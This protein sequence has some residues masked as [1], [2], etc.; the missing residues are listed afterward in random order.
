MKSCEVYLQPHV[1]WLFGVQETNYQIPSEK[2]SAI[3]QVFAPHRT[4]SGFEK[5]SRFLS[6]LAAFDFRTPSTTHSD[7]DEIGHWAGWVCIMF[8]FSFFELQLSNPC[9]SVKD[10]AA[11]LRGV[12][13]LRFRPSH[14]TAGPDCMVSM[15]RHGCHPS[16]HTL[17]Q[18][19]HPTL[20]FLHSI[21]P[22][23]DTFYHLL[24]S[25]LMRPSKQCTLHLMNLLWAVGAHLKSYC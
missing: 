24:L 4:H 20:Y 12:G 17:E 2:V 8:S 25:A 15:V 21:H 9:R 16:T 19:F 6:F 23:F 1:L 3:V 14:R 13:K 7:V 18:I 22:Q 11:P 10:L 5:Q